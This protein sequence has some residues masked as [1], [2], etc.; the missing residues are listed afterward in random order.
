MQMLAGREYVEVCGSMVK[1]L[2]GKV[3]QEGRWGQFQVV[4][5]KS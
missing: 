1:N 2:K 4:L 5:N 3:S